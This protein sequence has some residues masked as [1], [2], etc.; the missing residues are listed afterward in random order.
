MRI[1]SSNPTT[2]QA[3]I[4]LSLLMEATARK[5]GNVHP[6]A[7]YA[8]LTYQ[9]FVSSAQAIAPILV[10][11]RS[12]SVGETILSA[13]TASKKHSA[14]NSHLGTIFLLAPMAAV[15]HE[16]P[17]ATGLPTIL[18]QLTR[19]DAEKVYAAIAVANPG[20]MG[21]V[22]DNDVSDIPSGTLLAVMQQAEDRDLVAAQ[23]GNG[24]QQVLQ[25]GLDHLKS[26]WKQPDDWE[27]AIISLQLAF[28][29]NYPD[30]LIA[31]KCGLPM[32]EISATKAAEVINLGWPDS[33][34]SQQALQKFDYWLRADS[35]RRNPGTTADLI[36]ACLFAVIRDQTFHSTFQSELIQSPTFREFF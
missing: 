29:A 15:P 8:D 35:N 6:G 22:S 2:L 33:P 18:S 36:T 30:S 17:L 16:S 1:Q 4:L 13:V 24:F 31:R 20:G 27:T 32:A 12:V 10:Q 21:T 14:S 28:M 19:S 23:F 5:P 11:A 3:A 25:F 34:Q 7:A 9:D 26:I